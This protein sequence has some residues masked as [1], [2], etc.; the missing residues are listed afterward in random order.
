M[1]WHQRSTVPVTWPR[2]GPGH[3]HLGAATR[4]SNGARRVSLCAALAMT[5]VLGCSLPS[6]AW[7]SCRHSEDRNATLPVGEAA[8]VKITAGAGSLDVSG[9]SG[10]DSVRVRGRACAS[11]Q[12]ALDQIELET[13][14][15]ESEILI[16]AKI[17]SGRLFSNAT[18]DLHI[19]LPEAMALAIT[20]GSGE[21]AIRNARSVRLRDGSGATAIEGIAGEVYVEDGSGSVR[22]S[23]VRGDVALKDGSGSVSVTGIGGGVTIRDGSGSIEIEHV[24]GDVTVTEDGSGSISARHVDGDFTVERDGSGSVSVDDIRGRVSVRD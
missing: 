21:V 6:A 14:R 9:R 2:L 10:L 20:D 3:S 23:N 17:P 15:S 1:P 19:E 12:E 8:V 4:R 24:E 5:T 16:E 13:D 11:S 18:L 22:I 7:N